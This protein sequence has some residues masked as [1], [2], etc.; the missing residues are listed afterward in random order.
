MHDKA[1]VATSATLYSC[2][3]ISIISNEIYLMCF[4][5]LSLKVLQALWGLLP[6]M[7]EVNCWGGGGPWL[8]TGP[9]CN[10]AC[11]V[12]ILESAD[13]VGAWQTHPFLSETFPSFSNTIS[14]EQLHKWS[15][16][17]FYVV[18]LARY[19][20]LF[21]MP[22]I[23]CMQ[24]SS[25]CLQDLRN[26]VTSRYI[27]STVHLISAQVPWLLIAKKKKP[28]VNAYKPMN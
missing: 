13:C 24:F 16:K 2:S 18:W 6:Y 10:H 5:N 26:C 8:S 1:F 25:F 28:K 22:H 19:R 4:V 14:I 27:S 9:T 23:A 15:K 12:T 7:F 17:Y 3:Y 11:M 21:Q 20:M